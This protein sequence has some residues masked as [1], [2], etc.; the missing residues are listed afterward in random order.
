MVLR[1]ESTIDLP[2]HIGS[3][4]FD[5]AAVY[6]RGRRQYVA[7]TAKDAVDVIDLDS[8]RYLECVGGLTESLLMT[9]ALAQSSMP[10]T[11]SCRRPFPFLA[12]HAGRSSTPCPTGS[13]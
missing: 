7:H 2:E 11:Q 13:S 10:S 12:G 5:H 9:R 1:P 4:G 3:G 8:G 6:R